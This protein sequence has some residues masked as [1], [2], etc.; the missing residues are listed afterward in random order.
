MAL[1]LRR[2]RIV[3]VNGVDTSGKTCFA[4]S[5]AHFLQARGHHVA[6]VHVD[7]F[8]NPRAVRAQ[9][10]DPVRSYINHAFDLSRLE[11]ALL[12]PAWQVE[13][14]DL[15]LIHISEPTRPY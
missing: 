4:Q 7:D 2:A 15:S 6:L 8:H 13:T 12:V 9:G 14:V 10:A 1:P 5:L 11:R 3:G